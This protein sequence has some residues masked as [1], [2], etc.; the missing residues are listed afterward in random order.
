MKSN[1]TYKFLETNKIYRLKA[2][3]QEEE[4]IF[5]QQHR[6][7]V[8]RSIQV[9]ITNQKTKYVQF[10]KYGERFWKKETESTEKSAQKFGLEIHDLPTFSLRKGKNWK[11]PNWE[12]KEKK[13]RG[14]ERLRSLAGCVKRQLRCV[15][16]LFCYKM[17]DRLL[18]RA[19]LVISFPNKQTKRRWKA[20]KFLFKI[21]RNWL[22]DNLRRWFS[23][24]VV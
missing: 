1:S 2:N 13:R 24:R 21:T 20:P 10:N 8:L 17:R 5:F 7:P 3:Q 11:K 15:F 14:I 23:W 4:M 22:L 9:V 16:F 12:F 19:C 18:I 6:E